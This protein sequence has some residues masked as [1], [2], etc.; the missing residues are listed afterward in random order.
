MNI[1]IVAPYWSPF[2]GGAEVVAEETATWLAARHEVTVHTARLERARHGARVPWSADVDRVGEVEIRR[3]ATVGPRPLFYP[4]LGGAEIV[5]FHGFYRPLLLAVVLE[6]FHGPLVVQPHGNLSHERGG[7]APVRLALR[8]GID[9]RAIPALAG[10]ISAAVYLS[11]DERRRLEAMGLGARLLLYLPGP[12]RQSMVDRAKARAA[13]PGGRDPD[14]FAVVSR[15]VPYKYVEHALLAAARIPAVRLA[16]VSASAEPAYERRLRALARDLDIEGR[17]SWELSAGPDQLTQI[18]SRAVGT[19]LPSRT[20][21]WPLSVAESVLFGAIPVGTRSA[22][23]H[24]AAD[25]GVPL[26]YEWG[27]IDELVGLMERI[28]DDAGSFAEPLAEGRKW[29]LENLTPEAAGGRLEELYRSLLRARAGDC[30][31]SQAGDRS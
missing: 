5:H 9:N 7:Q 24:A 18:L 14:L 29:V 30:G 12:V 23:G 17:V 2:V 3:Y 10:R 6:S 15:L 8:R 4:S 16:I 26:V 19:V 20:E 25:M 21:G 31:S 1:H 22:V 13:V 28:H 11:T 27:D